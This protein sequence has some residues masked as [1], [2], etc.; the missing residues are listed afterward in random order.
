MSHTRTTSRTLGSMTVLASLLLTA[1]ISAQTGVSEDRVSLPEGPGSLEGVG[2][3][4]EMDPNMGNMNYNVPI[5]VPK[6]F[7]SVTPQLAL[8]YTSGGGGGVVG[9]GWSFNTPS[10]E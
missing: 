7:D 5:E 10:I 8:G 9:M 2:E 4:V 3:N 6:G 1:P